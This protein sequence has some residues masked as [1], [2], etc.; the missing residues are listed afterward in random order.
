MKII[1]AWKSIM[2]ER[3]I[4]DIDFM[5]DRKGVRVLCETSFW[6]SPKELHV[7]EKFPPL[8]SLRMLF[9]GGHRGSCNPDFWLSRIQALV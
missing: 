9:Y 1:Q 8:E 4:S 6:I 5:L 3:S 7:L 2:E